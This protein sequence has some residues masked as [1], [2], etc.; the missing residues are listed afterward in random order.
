MLKINNLSASIVDKQILN[1]INLNISS[2]EQHIL[3]GP[4]GSGKSSL[5]VCLMGHPDYKIL[6]GQ[7]LFNDRDI[8]NLPPHERARLG[9]FLAFQYPKAIP[10]LKVFSFLK[11]IYES[12]TGNVISVPDF[13]KLLNTNLEIVGIDK[14]FIHRDV[15][16]GFSGGEKKR[17]EMLQLLLLKPKLAIIDEIDSGLDVDALKVVAEVIN[18]CHQQNPNFTLILITH[19]QRILKYLKPDFVHILQK[20]K[21]VKTGGA[22]LALQIEKSG[23]AERL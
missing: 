2:G 5:A 16:D 9:I 13:E 15:N 21:I 20:G 17:F 18:L 6:A 12:F 7:I 1:Q 23:Y 11:T 19:Y 14:S 8:T 3:M 10:G 22:E 4:N